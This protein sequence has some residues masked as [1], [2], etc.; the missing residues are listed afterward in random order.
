MP[1]WIGYSP[2]RRGMLSQMLGV[3]EQGSRRVAQR[4]PL[5]GWYPSRIATA[6]VERTLVRHSAPSVL[7]DCLGRAASGALRGPAASIQGE[8]AAPQRAAGPKGRQ[9]YHQLLPAPG[10]GA[11][12]TCR[13]AD[14]ARGVAETPPRPARDPCR[15]PV[16]RGRP[17]A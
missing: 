3:A 14:G 9:P 6:S 16:L 7:H 8:A 4:S 13:P 10:Y 17:A 11:G 12:T 1:D 2:T 5:L 15:V